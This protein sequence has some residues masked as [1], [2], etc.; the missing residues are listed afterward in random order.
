MDE[1]VIIDLK[2]SKNLWPKILEIADKAAPLFAANFLRAIAFQRKSID[3]VLLL[4]AVI[5]GNRSNIDKVL[6][7]QLTTEKMMKMQKNFRDT[8]FKAAQ[9]TNNIMKFNTDPKMS[10]AFRYINQYAS[11]KIKNI[12][13]ETYEAIT[14]VLNRSFKGEL[15]NKE[16]ANSIKNFI[17]LD[18]RR[19]N[20][21]MSYQNALYK[22]GYP[23][24]VIQKMVEDRRKIMIKQRAT[25][26]ARTESMS[27][28]NYGNLAMY[29][30]QVDRGIIDKNKYCMAW[31]ITPDDR[32]CD[33]CQQMKNQKVDIGSNFKNVGLKYMSETHFTESPPLHPQCRC[34]I[35]LALK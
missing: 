8:A 2:A 14:A 5:S 16:V 22:D 24:K 3:P 30:D 29:K 15:T 26:I 28:S 4:N 9:E 31:M 27:A 32:L 18:E 13:K 10:Y 1:E 34:T 17:G 35:Y 33:R 6:N 25:V 21:L 7:W 12:D 20:A 19:Y 11:L 23:E